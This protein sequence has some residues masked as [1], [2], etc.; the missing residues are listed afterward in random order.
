MKI[1]PAPLLFNPALYTRPIYVRFGSSHFTKLAQRYFNSSYNV[2]FARKKVLFNDCELSAIFNNCEI[3]QT[4]LAVNAACA[5]CIGSVARMLS[6]AL[7]KR[8]ARGCKW[9]FACRLHDLTRIW[10]QPNTLL[11]DNLKYA[12]FFIK[13]YLLRK[14]NPAAKIMALNKISAVLQIS[15]QPTNVIICCLWSDHDMI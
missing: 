9:G 6:H 7:T 4:A 5:A 15:N 13:L 10:I 11:K 2:I 3:T 8:R 12:R 1:A 14:F